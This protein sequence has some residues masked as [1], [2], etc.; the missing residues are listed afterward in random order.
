MQ[1]EFG[2][3]FSHNGTHYKAAVLKKGLGIDTYFRIEYKTGG[4]EA[5]PSIIFIRLNEEDPETANPFW[6]QCAGTTNPL[7]EEFISAIGK[8]IEEAAVPMK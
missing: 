7:E 1:Q 2:I 8:S 5:P 4:L 3:R 6:Q